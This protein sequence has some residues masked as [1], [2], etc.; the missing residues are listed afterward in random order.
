[1]ICMN[2]NEALCLVTVPST[3]LTSLNAEVWEAWDGGRH[4]KY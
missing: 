3:K 4:L 1:M 2:I